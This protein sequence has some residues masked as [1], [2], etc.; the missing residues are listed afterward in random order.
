MDQATHEREKAIYLYINALE[1]GDFEQVG[2][3]LKQA[4]TDPELEK[5]IDEAHEVFAEEEELSE[6]TEEEQA[7]VRK[8]LAELRNSGK[9]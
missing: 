1:R 4:E 2:E 9:V 6:P 3:I 8:T 5:M 7:F